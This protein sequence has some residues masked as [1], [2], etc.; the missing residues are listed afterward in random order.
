MQRFQSVGNLYGKTG[1]VQ[2]LVIIIPPNTPGLASH[3]S[4]MSGG[5]MAPQASFFVRVCV[6]RSI[7][8]GL[9]F[10]WFLES[11]VAALQ[12]H[13]SRS[14]INCCFAELWFNCSFFF[15]L[16]TDQAPSTTKAH[17]NYPGCSLHPGTN[18]AV[19]AA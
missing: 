11:P 15:P 12:I 3:A 18:L 7:V 16:R 1:R 17:L 6:S 2:T 4:P 14:L 19:A 13:R 5:V 10:C 9:C 8:C